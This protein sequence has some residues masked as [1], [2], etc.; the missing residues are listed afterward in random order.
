M[1][2]Y[3]VRI[4]K[5]N[6]E[7]LSFVDGIILNIKQSVDRLNNPTDEEIIE[8]YVAYNYGDDSFPSFEEIDTVVIDEDWNIENY[9]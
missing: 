6:G 7:A 2:A 8:T 9:R 1:K 5:P 4:Y 3:E